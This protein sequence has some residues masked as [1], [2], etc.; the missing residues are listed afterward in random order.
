MTGWGGLSLSDLGRS[1][2]DYDTPFVMN[3]AKRDVRKA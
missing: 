3:P 1:A 2:D